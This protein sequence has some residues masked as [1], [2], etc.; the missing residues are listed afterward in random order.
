MK[1]IILG[2]ILLG[3]FAS[4][5]PVLMQTADAATSNKKICGD[6]LCSEIK[7]KSCP[8]GELRDPINQKCYSGSSGW[9]ITGYFLP[10]EKDYPGDPLVLAYVQG[11]KK[12]GSFDY[13]ENNSTYYLKQFRSTFL[14]EIAIQG[15]GK[16]NENKILQSW[17]YDFVSPNGEKTR[18]YHYEKCAM[19]FSGICL[20][21][22][23]SSLNEPTIMVAVTAG[24]TDMKT[25]IISHGTLLRISDIPS[26]WN[27]RT[28]WATDIGE[29]N[30]KHIDVFTGYGI[31]AR[32][33]AFKITKLPPQGDS[34]VLAVGF[35]EI[36]P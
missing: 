21:L 18:F 28:Y 9:K 22:A 8:S 13:S 33:A 11:V 31:K 23:T 15:S 19:T 10:L 2:V 7:G 1:Q 29:W 6:K 35:N 4:S 5:I 30:D 25:G 27:T 3:I 12:N 36:K 24:K 16:T 20:P 34:R 17:K 26:P 32:E 14:K